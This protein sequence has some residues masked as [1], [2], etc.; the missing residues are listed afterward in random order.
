[1]TAATPATRLTG[2]RL[3]ELLVLAP[4]ILCAVECTGRAV[5]T[6]F[7][8]QL[9]SAWSESEGLERGLWALSVVMAAVSVW[10]SGTRPLYVPGLFLLAVATGVVGIVADEDGA[11]KASLAGIVLVQL[12][13]LRLRFTRTRLGCRSGSCCAPSAQTPRPT[14]EIENGF[15]ELHR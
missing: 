7:L 9:L 5:L 1:M 10:R 12:A 6:A 14:R 13:T 2:P 11:M 4:P 15:A 8:P 3:R